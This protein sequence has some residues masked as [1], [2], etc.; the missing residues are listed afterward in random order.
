MINKKSEKFLKARDTLPDD[1]KPIY[2]EL[3]E[4]YAFHTERFFGRGY[5]AYEVLAALVRDGW[6]FSAKPI[7]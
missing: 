2:D 1:L 7:K 3:V 6:R 4:Q 5:V